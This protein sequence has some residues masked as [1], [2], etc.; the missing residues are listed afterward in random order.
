MRAKFD[1]NEHEV[2]ALTDARGTEG[3]SRPSAQRRSGIA[4]VIQASRTAE[5]VLIAATCAGCATSN[6]NFDALSEVGSH[7]RGARLS[8][9]L[10]LEMEGGDQQELYDIDVIPLARTHLHVFEDRRSKGVR[11]SR[12]VHGLGRVGT[13]G[14]ARSLQACTGGAP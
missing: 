4:G 8:E 6:Y 10:G 2:R 13:G 9:D 12:Q 5:L 7:S 11:A 14:T 1:T 3:R